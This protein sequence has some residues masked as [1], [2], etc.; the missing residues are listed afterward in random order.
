LLLSGL[1]H[2]DQ[3]HGPGRGNEQSRHEASFS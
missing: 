3:A 2:A 1:E